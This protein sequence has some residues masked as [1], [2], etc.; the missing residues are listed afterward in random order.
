MSVSFS[1]LVYSDRRHPP[2]TPRNQRL[3]L[4]CKL[5]ALSCWDKRNSSG[6]CSKLS[7]SV[8][9]NSVLCT[10][11]EFGHKPL[12]EGGYLLF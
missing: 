11:L 1:L 10:H 8:S 2:V 5:K 9:L 3:S 7:R 4:I 12:T 6:S